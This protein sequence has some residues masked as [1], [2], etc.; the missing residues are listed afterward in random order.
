MVVNSIQLD[1]MLESWKIRRDSVIPIVTC[2]LVPVRLAIL[3]KRAGLA[4]AGRAKRAKF[5]FFGKKSDR[6]KFFVCQLY[7]SGLKKGV[8]IWKEGMTAK[9]LE[10]I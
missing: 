7:T 5:I 3:G 6:E 10:F 4:M 9:L 8:I 2:P 1:G